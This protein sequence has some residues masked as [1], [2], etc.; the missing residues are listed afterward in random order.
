MAMKVAANGE[1]IKALRTAALTELPQ[2]VLAA[3]CNISERQ[4][5]RI[6]NDNLLVSLPILKRLASSLGV[7]PADIAFGLDGPTLVPVKADAQIQTAEVD[8][9]DK[10]HI[11]R[12]RTATLGPI[13]SARALYDLAAGCQQIVP[14][15]LVDAAPAQFEMIEECV[16]ILT[17]VSRRE[18][19]IAEPVVRD[20]Y[21]DNDFPELARHKRLSE[22]VV[23]LKGHDI[24]IVVDKEIY[25]YPVGVT[26][27]LPDQRFCFQLVVAFAPPRGQYEEESVVVPFD[28]GRD[29]VLPR[30]SIF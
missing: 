6:E 19:S 12:H 7:E 8:D 26:P 28:G 21:D 10:L 3:Q 20:A 5:R 22:L 16:G 13:S 2:K 23:L 9:S 18:W 30:K 29:H 15:V 4:L 25:D 24:R 11:P 14:H 1:R 17:T 27:W